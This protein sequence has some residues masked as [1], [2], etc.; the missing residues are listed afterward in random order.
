MTARDA[1][2]VVAALL[3]VAGFGLAWLP[4]GVIAAGL[5]VFGAWFFLLDDVGGDE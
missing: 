5:A 4:L 2:V 3:V 1:V